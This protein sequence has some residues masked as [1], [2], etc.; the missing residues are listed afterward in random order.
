MYGGILKHF[1]NGTGELKRHKSQTVNTAIYRAT[2][3]STT[4]NISEKAKEV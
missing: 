1:M 4:G 2:Q 3:Q